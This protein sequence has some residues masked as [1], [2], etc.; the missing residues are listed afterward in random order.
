MKKGPRTIFVESANHSLIASK[1][2]RFSSESNVNKF[3]GEPC[4][5]WQN[6][7]AKG[8]GILWL[9]HSIAYAHRTAYELHSQAKIPDG[10]EVCHK[11]DNTAC[12]NPKH[13]FLATHQE[14]MQDA[15]KKKRLF[16][17]TGENSYNGKFSDA[18]ANYIRR[19]F[20][21]SSAD[22]K[23]IRQLAK[24]YKVESRVIARIVRF[25]SYC[26]RELIKNIEENHE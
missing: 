1:L 13:L 22:N 6:A 26:D 5:E 2:E 20:L 16:F 19:Q 4:I 23:A 7:F 12:I 10:L 3:Q 17:K 18:T 8:Y 9:G 25:I 21:R 11:C 15:N 24:K 14:N